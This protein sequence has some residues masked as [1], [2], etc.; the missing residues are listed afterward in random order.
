MKKDELKNSDKIADIEK[1][2]LYL[3]NFKNS[4][5]SDPAE[6][7][8]FLKKASEISENIDFKKGNARC[9][10]SFG[11]YYLYLSDYSNAE[12]HLVNALEK[13]QKISDG[14]LTADILHSLGNVNYS[15]GYYQKSLEDYFKSLELR[16]KTKETNHLS[17]ANTLNNIGI[18]F[19]NMN[20]F[21]S[22]LEYY[23]KS[24]ELKQK[25]GNERSVASTMNNIGLILNSLGDYER[26]NEYMFKSLN[27]IR[28]NKDHRGEAKILNN[29]GMNY[30]FL[31]DYDEA[32]DYYQKSYSL[33]KLD[34]N[35]KENAYVLNNLGTIH[36][37][38]GDEKSAIKK[39]EEAIKVSISSGETKSEA[40][41]YMNKGVSL[42]NLGKIEEAEKN[43][44]KSISIAGSHGFNDISALC[45]STLSDILYKQEKYKEA[46]EFFKK[47]RD[48]ERD[49][50]NETT[51]AQTR[52]LII[53]HDAEQLKKETKLVKEK[54]K[55]LF[56]VINRLD[57]INEEK[58]NILGI[59]AHDLRDP[60]S[61]I[62]S[63][64]DLTLTDFE[65]LGKDEVKEFIH[66]IKIS[67][68]KVLQILHTLLNLNAIES[69]NYEM[70]YLSFDLSV[71]LED[72]C[73]RNKEAAAEK[74]IKIYFK[75]EYEFIVYADTNSVDQI[76]TNL[77]TNAIKY[78]IPDS[79]IIITIENNKNFIRTRIKD[80]GPG[81]TE[82]DKA[83]LFEKFAKLSAKPTAG[84]QSTGLGLSIV[85]KLIE[86]NKGNISLES[87][88]SK[89]SVFSVNLPKV[90]K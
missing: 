34:K 12:K 8:V 64:S 58:N 83:H 21:P 39:F 10:Y 66:S 88:S 29:I 71:L 51:V 84:E 22:A 78:S 24:L 74:R 79:E 23:L 75:N 59:V 70:N 55:E 35:D 48:I 15:L 1:V 81:F 56:K 14:E 18:V 17:E 69:G 47:F 45:Y 20:V 44:Q 19:R 68:E 7:L 9:Q 32:F 30:K 89:G 50:F 67:S 46:F 31:G 73:K 76:F 57:E 27:L 13:A 38:K 37:L 33:Y 77:L 54:N 63:L 2:T 49:I 85:K 3:S 42:S 16:K 90:S 80:N 25:Y 26:S 53:H 5:K 4:L 82:N 87:T 40:V 72:I 65:E 36:S 6:A 62:Y 86:L 41:G 43:I 28:E 61:A 11:L 60:V 52:S